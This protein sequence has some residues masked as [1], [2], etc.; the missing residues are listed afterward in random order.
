[1]FY[2]M[3]TDCPGFIETSTD[4]HISECVEEEMF[5]EQSAFSGVK[6]E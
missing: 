1:M 6:T 2:D 4:F 3:A 5:Y